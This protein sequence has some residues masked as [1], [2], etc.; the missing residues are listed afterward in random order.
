MMKLIQ[1]IV[2]L[3]RISAAPDTVMEYRSD[4]P[5]KVMAA[6]ELAANWPDEVVAIGVRH[7]AVLDFLRQGH[8]GISAGTAFIYCYRLHNY[9]C[10]TAGASK[11]PAGE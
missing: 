11:D 3:L 5:V 1:Q 9:L 6:L 7:K 2:L 8:T 4:T 10:Q